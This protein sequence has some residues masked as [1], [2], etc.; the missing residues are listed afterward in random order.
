MIT[1]VVL[2]RLGL[3]PAPSTEFHRNA[4]L[5]FGKTTKGYKASCL[6]LP[7]EAKATFW[8]SNTAEYTEVAG[9]RI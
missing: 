4:W 2:R 3:T 1:S 5:R 6:D 9:G 7:P 8:P